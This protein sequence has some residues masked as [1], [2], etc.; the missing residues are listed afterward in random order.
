M[1]DIFTSLVSI[2]P[3]ASTQE[4]NDAQVDALPKHQSQGQMK[5]SIFTKKRKNSVS[6]SV[7]R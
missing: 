7:K 6:K 4:E 3:S 2:Q 1:G 5:Q